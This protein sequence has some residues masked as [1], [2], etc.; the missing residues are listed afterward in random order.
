ME[1]S[2]E[3]NGGLVVVIMG[4]AGA[5]K[6]TIGELLSK[7]LNCPFVDA[8]DFHPDENKDKMRNGIPLSEDDR[9][10]WLEKLHDSV[11]GYLASGRAAILAC[12]ALRRSYRLVLRSAADGINPPGNVIFVHLKGPQELF[13]T[14]LAARH[15]EG[16]HFM[17]P[18]LLQSQLDLLEE[19]DDTDFESCFITVDASLRPDALVSQIKHELYTRHNL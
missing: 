11:A 1:T 13:E 12:S 4:V 6:S 7:D 15:K 17:P 9:R 5:G 2:A 18:S 19:E 8:D 16:K 14:R 3:M 10:P